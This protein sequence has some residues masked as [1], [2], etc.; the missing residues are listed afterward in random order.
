ML[1]DNNVGVDDQIFRSTSHCTFCHVKHCMSVNLNRTFFMCKVKFHGLFHWSIP[2]GTSPELRHLLLGMLKRNAK[3]RITFEDFFS[4]KFLRPRASKSCKHTTKVSCVII[5]GKQ[6]STCDW[7]Y[8]SI[9]NE[10][11]H[12]LFSHSFSSTSAQNPISKHRER[13]TCISQSC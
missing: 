8:S 10:S 6:K 7:G 11:N 5:A 3:D 2:S 9:L 12:I 1:W 13:I 4:H